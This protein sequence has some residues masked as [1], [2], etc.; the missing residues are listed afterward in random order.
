MVTHSFWP[1]LSTT[2]QTSS[3]AELSLSTFNI[4]TCLE[5]AGLIILTLAIWD[6][7]PLSQGL[8]SGTARFASINVAT[9]CIT[10]RT[11]RAQQECKQG[12]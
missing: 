9:Y 12:R 5:T 11:T 4:A 8:S 10:L 3:R 7:G 6:F 1:R 2:G